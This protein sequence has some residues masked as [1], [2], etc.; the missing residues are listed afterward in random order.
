MTLFLTNKIRLQEASLTAFKSINQSIK[1]LQTV[2]SNNSK[3]NENTTGSYYFICLDISLKY[4][5][6]FK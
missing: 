5:A 1:C 3:S 2:L 6:I 4:N